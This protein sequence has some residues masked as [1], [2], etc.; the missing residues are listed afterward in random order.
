MDAQLMAVI[1]GNQA[2]QRKAEEWNKRAGRDVFHVPTSEQ[3]AQW[4]FEKLGGAR[5]MS[6][7]ANPNVL[8]RPAPDQAMVDEILRDNPDQIKIAGQYYSVVYTTGRPVIIMSV[9]DQYWRHLPDAGVLL[10]GGRV[11]EV[12]FSLDFYNVISGTDIPVLKEQ[13]R[14]HLINRQWESWRRPG[15]ALPDPEKPGTGVSA[16]LPVQY[17]TC[18]VTGGSLWA[19]GVARPMM[20]AMY[21]FQ[22]FEAYWTRDKA[23]AESVYAQSVVKLAEVREQNRIQKEME[24]LRDEVQRQNLQLEELAHRLRSNYRLQDQI[25]QRR[26]ALVP[27]T[28][29]GLQDR[30]KT[31]AVLIEE[32]TAAVGQQPQVA[33]PVVTPVPAARPAPSRPADFTDIGGRWFRCPTQHS[34]KVD[35]AKYA[36]YEAGKPIFIE[37]STCYAKGTITKA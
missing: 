36:E 1:A 9:H 32:L 11:V 16:P 26:Y 35:K 6:E 23:E 14:Q 24:R 18:A 37:C 3:L 8:R 20:Y 13:V 31:T 12:R 4:V 34:V 27:A 22:L 30:I 33:R 28:I 25:W 7:I 10:P 2:G 15:L 21:S 29:T 17:G 19:Y 5:R